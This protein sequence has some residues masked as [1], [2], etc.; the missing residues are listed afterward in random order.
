MCREREHVEV[1][2]EGLVDGARAPVK[3]LPAEGWIH[4]KAILDVFFAKEVADISEARDRTASAIKM[5][6]WHMGRVHTG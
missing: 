2:V 6:K 1:R 3:C 5:N 4:A